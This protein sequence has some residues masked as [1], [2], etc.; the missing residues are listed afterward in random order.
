MV[1][2]LSLLTPFSE[3]WN[4]GLYAALAFGGI[5]GY[6][7]IYS[8]PEGNIQ[9]RYI[10]IAVQ[11]ADT[12]L[13]CLQPLTSATK[14]AAQ[15]AEKKPSRNGEG[16]EHLGRWSIQV[17]TIS[18]KIARINAQCMDK[19]IR[20]WFFAS[21]GPF[22]VILLSWSSAS[23]AV[24]WLIC[25]SLSSNPYLF[26]VGVYEEVY[27]NCYYYVNHIDVRLTTEYNSIVYRA[28]YW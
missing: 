4:A 23:Q 2:W 28:L 18:A 10:S 27:F 5:M 25:Y 26:R 12:I 24:S 21:P 19:R 22:W 7:S 17:K 15:S 14:P 1:L 6:N 13:N 20:G 8:Y 3:H 11:N 9:C 16:K